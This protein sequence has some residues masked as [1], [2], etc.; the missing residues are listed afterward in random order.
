MSHKLFRGSLVFLLSLS[1][2]SCVQTPVQRDAE[3][4]A[5][6]RKVELTVKGGRI[7]PPDEPA[8][9]PAAMPLAQET[10]EPAKAPEKSPKEKEGDEL[11][12][13]PGEKSL[14]GEPKAQEGF[15]S[16]FDPD[17]VYLNAISNLIPDNRLITVEKS[18]TLTIP[19]LLE[20]LAKFGNFNIAVADGLETIKI[21]RVNF[22]NIPLRD[23]FVAI[24]KRY[25]LNLTRIGNVLWIDG[26]NQAGDSFVYRVL[27]LHSISASSLGTQL[28][29]ILSNGSG[30]G[31]ALPASG[32]PGGTGISGATS[33][34]GANGF[35]T[36]H[37]DSNTIFIRAKPELVDAMAKF[38]TSVD[39]RGS[40]VMIE[41]KVFEV[42]IEDNN[43]IGSAF[44][45][46]DFFTP[47][48]G[49]VDSLSNF[50][51]SSDPKT[52]FDALDPSSTSQTGPA[53][54]S[55]DA[56]L[57]RYQTPGNRVQGFL[58]FLKTISTLDLLS[59][60]RIVA[61]NGKPAEI[62]IIEKIPYIQQTSTTGTGGT[63]TANTVLF[64]EVG[65]RLRVTPTIQEDKHIR[66]VVEPEVS[67]EKTKFQGVPVVSKRTTKTEVVIANGDT[68][69]IGG[70]MKN[71]SL[72][73]EE[74]VPIL[75]DI[76]LL[77]ILFRRTEE[78]HR[79]VELLV[80]IT[81]KL[82]EED[83]A[84]KEM[85]EKEMERIITVRKG[86]AVPRRE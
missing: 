55:S 70:L 86:L 1:L 80:L 3:S 14:Q 8:P 33:S 46:A 10:Q 69:A 6:E 65:I 54:N 41:M 9:Q 50:L 13:K 21:S 2:G 51:F 71:S 84:A 22:P 32:S 81:P 40:Q 38:I 42:S 56:F 17:A 36:I 58:E 29:Q 63:T 15:V 77:G 11:I 30:G 57:L 12:M 48:N 85:T 75:G 72:L 59:S 44:S 79:K 83:S 5:T 53:G 19:Q 66:M 78:T 7:V 49:N 35:F 18:E 52:T 76:P 67:E 68:F 25:K 16:P 62:N 26:G 47:N 61:V 39:F 20:A 37:P 24:L 34:S 4:P 82:I 31:A 74:K 60:P 64:E 28:S 43:K 27:R 23:A 45:A 73:V